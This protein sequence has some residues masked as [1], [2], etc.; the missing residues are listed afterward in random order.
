MT[1]Y[2]ISFVYGEDALNLRL[3]ITQLRQA[4]R[5]AATQEEAAQLRRRIDA[6]V[7]LLRQSREL[8]DLTRHYYERSYHRNE[9]YTL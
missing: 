2:E 4:L 8:A 9:Q 3:R 5:S 7:V 6:L 1:L